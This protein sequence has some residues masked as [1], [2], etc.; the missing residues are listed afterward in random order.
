MNDKPASASKEKIVHMAELVAPDG[1]VSALCFAKPRAID[2]RKAT[3]TNR[4]YAVT[5]KKCIVKF[6]RGKDV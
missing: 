6:K 3:W 1:S 2:L 5:C 4:P